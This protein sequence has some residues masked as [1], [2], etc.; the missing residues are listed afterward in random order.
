MPNRVNPP[1]PDTD[2]L[3]FADEESLPLSDMTA[4]SIRTHEF[5]W[6]ILVVDDDIEVHAITNLILRDFSFEGR[7]VELFCG[8]SGSDARRLLQEHPDAAILLLDVVMETESAGLEMV[9]YVRNELINPYIRI[10]LRTGQPG[11]APEE[12]I[13]V[14]Y[15]IND[16]KDK[17]SLSKQQLTTSIIASL[18]SYRDLRALE[19]TRKG[20]KK[21]IDATADLFEPCS[22]KT[23][24]S[25]I[26]TQLASLI[27]LEQQ[28][29]QSQS[30]CLAFS[31]RR[32]KINVYAKSGRFEHSVGTSL[33]QMVC[34]ETF[35]KISEGMKAKKSLFFEHDYLGYFQSKL[36]IENFIFMEGTQ[37]I[38]QIEKNLLEIFSANISFAFDNLFLNREILNTQRDVTFTLGE[39]IEVRSQEAGH[40]VRR[41]AMYSK[42]LA[43][44]FGLSEADTELLFMASPLHDLGKIGI[45]DH[46]LHKPDKL[47]PKEFAII[48]SHATIGY[49]ILKK[50]E[51]SILKAGAIIAH[52]H[53]EK[54]NGQGYPNG[55]HG[56]QIHIFARITAIADVFDALIDD[57]CYRKAW[58]LDR[59]LALFEEEKG[60]HFEPRLIEIFFENLEEILEIK[61]NL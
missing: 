39:V 11:Y 17:A 43:A 18:R 16:Y 5:P 58:Q 52:Q 33:E 4:K 56:E 8:H 10:I 24:A 20:L 12:K 40:H 54:W 21:I 50:S 61:K 47:D 19:N 15:D 22:L 44:K 27:G 31:E 45:P 32:G 46:I 23:L 48:Q 7:P 1:I 34:Q 37:P 35:E 13:I 41:V 2:E 9:R 53:H 51:R 55:L 25:G 49:D 28:G 6:K 60:Q 3:L 14:E 36:G 29:I 30:S 26:L 59:V 57:R 38:G 42:L